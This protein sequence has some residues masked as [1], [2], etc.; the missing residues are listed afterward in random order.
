MDREQVIALQHQRFAAKKYD[1][2]RRISQKDW[3]ALVEVGRLAPSSI[4]LEPWKMLLLKN[5]RM[6]EDLKPMA[7]GALFGLEGASHFVIYLARKGV[8]YDS[9]YVKKV[10][11]EV[12]K[13]DYDT[14]SRFAQIIKNFQENDMKLNSERSLFDWASKQTYIQMANMMMV[15]AMLGIDSCPIEGYDQEKVEAYLEEKG[16]LNTAEFGVSVMACFGYRNQ[17]ITP[18]TRWKTE[19]IY[20]VIE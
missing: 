10:M 16:Y 18:K 1:P 15:A 19:V 2:N 13:R 4:G 6:K 20:E 8:T 17:E 11:H 3:E 14:N 12:K 7:W 5:E 9:D